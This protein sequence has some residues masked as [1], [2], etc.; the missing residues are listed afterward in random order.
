MIDWVKVIS[1]SFWLVGFALLLAVAGYADYHR[2]L[3]YLSTSEAWRIAVHKGWIRLGGLL[4]CACMALTGVNWIE[5]GL[6]AMPALYILYNWPHAL[7][8]RPVSRLF[9]VADP[10]DDHPQ[11]TSSR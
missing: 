4:F 7:R 5:M 9:S 6:W 11:A 2:S 10:E 3:A 1:S 8:A